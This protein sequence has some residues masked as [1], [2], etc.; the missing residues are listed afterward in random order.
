ML[1]IYSDGSSTV[2]DGKRYGAFCTL[3]IGDDNE[4]IKSIVE[5][6]EDATNNQME[7]M[8]VISGLEFLLSHKTSEGK[9]PVTVIADS[10]YVIK[11]CTEWMKGWKKKNWK[12]YNKK[13]VKNQE[14]WKRLDALINSPEI[15]ITWQ[16]VYGHQGKSTTIEEDSDVYFNEMCDSLC[17]EKMTEKFNV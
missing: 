13:P 3:F 1:R 5:G 10:D 2:S 9:L 14:Y 17:T 12:T 6:H 16:H 11:G 7:L 15:E 4:I 8:G